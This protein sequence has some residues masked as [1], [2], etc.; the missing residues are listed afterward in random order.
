MFANKKIIE[1]LFI[2][3]WVLTAFSPGLTV[4][5]ACAG[6]APNTYLPPI[7]I[8][9]QKNI[10]NDLYKAGIL[11]SH[12][13]DKLSKFDFKAGETYKLLGEI[14]QSNKYII[15]CAI[16]NASGILTS[17]EP[18]AHKSSE[19]VDISAQEHFKRLKEIKKPVLSHIFKSVEGTWGIAIQYPIF[20]NPGAGDENKSLK[21][22]LSLLINPELFFKD[23]IE[24]QTK[25]LPLKAW[26]MQIDGTM[27]YSPDTSHF[28]QNI[29]THDSYKSI[30]NIKKMSELVAGSETGSAML[31][32]AAENNKSTTESSL[33]SSNTLENVILK[34]AYWTTVGLFE[35]K[36][37]LFVILNAE[38]AANTN[39]SSAE[40]ASAPANLNFENKKAAF[41]QFAQNSQ[42][43]YN[44][45]NGKFDEV[46]KMFADFYNQNNGFYSLQYVNAQSVNKFGWPAENS[47]NNYDYKSSNLLTDT[48]FLLAAQKQ[49]DASFE[50][51]LIEGHTGIFFLT[52]VFKG[53]KYLGHIYFIM[54]K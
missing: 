46:K 28:G 3:L 10:V 2:C 21:G 38:Y 23:I 11:V 4:P 33:N 5:P 8:K 37:R 35:T 51:R 53:K 7:L 31:E 41:K 48:Q 30:R 47:L 9:L 19:G 52:P 42:L 24:R 34:K 27:L 17:I 16:I 50:A 15:D 26:L 43:I 54:L 36:W 32:I 18:A 6:T 39:A 20:D 13:V 44:I 29:F 25:G 1:I 40:V 12:N 22:A 49:E 45:D 14:C